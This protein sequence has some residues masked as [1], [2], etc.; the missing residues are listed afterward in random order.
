MR[1][2]LADHFVV[3]AV[4]LAAAVAAA[5]EHVCLL[6]LE[7]DSLFR[8]RK[9]Y[10]NKRLINLLYK[11]PDGTKELFFQVKKMGSNITSL[12]F[13]NDS[14]GSFVFRYIIERKYWKLHT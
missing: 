13:S 8:G 11:F 6:Q 10:T 5:V 7:K 12:N 3:V 9:N 4:D 14:D 2:H 1:Q